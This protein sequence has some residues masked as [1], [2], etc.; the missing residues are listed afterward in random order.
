MLNVLLAVY[1]LAGPAGR[2]IDD[3]R[4]I[5]A[6][7]LYEPQCCSDR[8]CRPLPNGAVRLVREGWLIVATGLVIPFNDRKIHASPDGRFHGCWAGGDA[9]GFLLCLYVPGFGS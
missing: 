2:H 7:W 1:A 3:S 4:V 8:D 5:K 6:H 9:R